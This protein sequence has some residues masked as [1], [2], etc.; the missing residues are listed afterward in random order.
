[1]ENLVQ[2][3]IRKDHF[4]RNY[5][6]GCSDPHQEKIHLKENDIQVDI[7]GEKWPL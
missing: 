3:H 7:Q 6:D 2:E 1:M 4:G 5:L